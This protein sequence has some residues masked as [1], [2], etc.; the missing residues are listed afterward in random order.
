M[1][2][3]PA[4][5]VN[6][7]ICIIGDSGVGKTS[8]IMRYVKG[9]FSN[10]YR[11]TV[12]ADLFSYELSHGG[13]TYLLQVW[14]TAG[15]E[16]FQTIGTAFYRGS[17]ACVIV[18]DITNPKSLSNVETWKREF[19][20]QGGVKDPAAFPFIVL[21]NKCDRETERAVEKATAEEFCKENGGMTLFETSAKEDLNVKEAFLEVVKRAS[22]QHQEEE[23]S[24]LPSIQIKPT[25]KKSSGKGCC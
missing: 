12:G 11:I 22:E 6:L 17:D 20:K 25:D 9:K 4:K 24:V 15:Q 2:A 14:D 3:P 5:K 7:K 18:Y 21:G 1:S 16:R 8:L 23:I 19:V 10:T 13:K